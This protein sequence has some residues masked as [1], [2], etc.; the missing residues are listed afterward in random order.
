MRV[1]VG[2]FIRN[3]FLKVDFFFRFFDHDKE[4]EGDQEDDD[5]HCEDIVEL[6]K[7]FNQNRGQ[8]AAKKITSLHNAN[9]DA[10]V[11]DRLIV[12]SW[13]RIYIVVLSYVED[14]DDEA[15]DE[16][17]DVHWSLDKACETNFDKYQPKSDIESVSKWSDKETW[18]IWVFSD[19]GV[20]KTSES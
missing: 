1:L 7:G 16:A 18:L 2:F 14:G 19:I 8:E 17:G 20:V 9:I 5:I 4:S 10:E 12:D 3:F 6:A 13:N 15:W 11:F